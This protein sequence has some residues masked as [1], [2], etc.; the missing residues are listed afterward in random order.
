MTKLREIVL[1]LKSVKEHSR[2]VLSPEKLEKVDEFNHKFREALENDLNTPQALA[3]T[4]EAIKS[5]IPSPDKLDLLYTFD[6]VLGLN[7]RDLVSTKKPIPPEI[8]QLVKSR[9]QA[10]ET[11]NFEESD[12]LREE[13]EKKGY[14]LSDTPN[15]TVV[16]AR[17]G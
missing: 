14:T 16:T 10:R 3:V 9:D 17:N 4:W 15:G 1:E 5:N 6:E 13:I 2:E 7:L 12:R 11:G 8:K